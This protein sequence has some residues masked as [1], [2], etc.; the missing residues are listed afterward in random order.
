MSVNV[1]ACNNYTAAEEMFMKSDIGSKSHY[2][3]SINLSFL[4][5]PNKN[6]GHLV[7][8]HTSISASI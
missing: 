7:Y 3:V 4:S 1:L 5:K 6:N 2:N 8:T